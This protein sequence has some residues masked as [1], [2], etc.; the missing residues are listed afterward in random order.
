MQV[1]R[2]RQHLMQ[3]FSL[4]EKGGRLVTSEERSPQP[5][6]NV[7]ADTGAEQ[8]PHYPSYG[9]EDVRE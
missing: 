6:Q 3:F 5:Q 2:Q 4:H 7:M 8:L 9:K 1:G